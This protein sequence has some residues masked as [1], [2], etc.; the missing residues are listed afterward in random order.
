MATIH[1]CAV[2][3]RRWCP[4]TLSLGPMQ[5]IVLSPGPEITTDHWNNREYELEFFSKVS[6]LSN[7]PLN[8]LQC[9][10]VSFYLLFYYRINFFVFSGQR[11]RQLSVRMRKIEIIGRNV[12]QRFVGV[13]L[14]TNATTNSVVV[15]EIEQR[16]RDQPVRHGRRRR[17]SK[18]DES[19]LRRLL[20][21]ALLHRTVR[22][23]F[24]T[25]LG[26]TI[27]RFAARRI[28]LL[29]SRFARTTENFERRRKERIAN[30]GQREVSFL[31]FKKYFL[32]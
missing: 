10:S 26:R 12:V 23:Q 32:F 9:S 21:G 8:R 11:R 2:F 24:P 13:R 7:I 19:R 22:I 14:R 3:V 30:S 5:E 25:R 18:R 28:A 4:S 29:L 6:Q 16:L 1:H 27:V 20:D 31:I 17:L 15:V